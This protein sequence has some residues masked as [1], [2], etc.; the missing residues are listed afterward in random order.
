MD[1]FLDLLVNNIG[2]V[3]AGLFSVL[4]LIFGVKVVSAKDKFNQVIELLVD[5]REAMKDNKISK[6]E[7]DEIIL[8][9]KAILGKK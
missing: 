6:E 2:I 1:A 9:V 4:T 3:S 5:I 8:D 7:L